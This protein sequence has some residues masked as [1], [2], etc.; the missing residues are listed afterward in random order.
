MSTDID[1]IVFEMP[2]DQ[3]IEFVHSRDV[4]QACANAVEAETIGKTFLIGGGPSNQ[5]LQREFLKK[6]FEGMGLGMLP[7]SAFRVATKPDE[8]YYTD[9]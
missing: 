1:P 6:I 5:M 7:D 8:Y 3:R 2:L 9:W 4:G